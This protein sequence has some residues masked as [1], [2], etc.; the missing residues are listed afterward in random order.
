M[1][2]MRDMED[3]SKKL[4]YINKLSKFDPY[5]V[6]FVGEKKLKCP[7]WGNE[8]YAVLFTGKDRRCS[9]IQYG[10]REGKIDSSGFN[11]QIERAAFSGWLKPWDV[12]V[13]SDTKIHTGGECSV[14][15]DFLWNNYRILV[16]YLPPRSPKYNPVTKIW[17]EVTHDLD[18]TRLNPY[19]SHDITH[20]TAYILDQ[21]SHREIDRFYAECYA[22]CG[23]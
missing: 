8:Y 6:K 7:F 13:M 5:R 16:V 17:K 1:S 15:E 18:R 9:P 2:I 11:D 20:A 21:F 4:E 14:N 10:I 12:L 23:L 3:I 22:E 19:R